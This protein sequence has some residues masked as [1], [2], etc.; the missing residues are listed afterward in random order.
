MQRIP[1]LTAAEQTTAA[2]ITAGRFSSVVGERPCSLFAPLHYEPNY[3]YPLLVWLHG[4]SDYEG[5]L[6]RIM[7]FVS[8]RNYVAVAP[9][10]SVPLTRS[11]RSTKFTWRQTRADIALAEQHVFDA[12]DLA[13][14][15]FHVA[16]ERV[17]LAGYDVGGT[18]AFRLAMSHPEQFAGVLSLC[19]GFP[20]GATPL[21]RLGQIRRLPVF[22]ACGRDSAT[23]PPTRVCD[24]L[25]LFHAA[26]LKVN[27]RQ[28][29]C[30]QQLTTG[31]LA[32]MDR[33][34]MELV[35]GVPVTTE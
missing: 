5:Q 20:E 14:A 6:T 3:A 27:L 30:T 13:R 8:L 24:D 22:L 28:Y 10:G 18:M 2:P 29:P 35:T 23:F 31:M 26:N 16:P 7:P 15:R 12:I 32:D 34:I 21:S 9:R 19:G 25:R 1:S 33:W 11:A 17:F 4:P